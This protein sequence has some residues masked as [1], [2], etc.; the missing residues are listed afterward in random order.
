[1]P[2]KRRLPGELDTLDDEA[3]IAY[4]VEARN[5]DEPEAMKDALAV[6]TNRR[7]PDLI[8]RAKLKV[9]EQDAEDVA[10]LTMTG[11]VLARFEGT[12]VGEFVNLTNRVLAR[13]IA[14]YHDKAERS[15]DTVELPEE[16]RD[17]QEGRR[18][19]DAA[20][21]QAEVGGVDAQSV[22]DQA[23]G[24]LSAEH[25]RTVELYVFEDLSAADTADQVNKEFPDSNP[26]MSVDNVQKI[27]SRFKKRFRK[28]LEGA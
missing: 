1:M 8:R 11:A 12:S 28:L 19:R 18:R 5:A 17:D 25:R 15:P 21:S 7:L 16:H 26:K 27:K 24:E 3:L 13:R 14:D 9:P 2:F 10:M 20:V 22:I 23:L 4:A 6:F